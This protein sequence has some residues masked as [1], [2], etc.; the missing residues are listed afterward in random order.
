MAVTVDTPEMYAAMTDLVRLMR[1]YG[2]P[3]QATIGWKM[4]SELYRAG[5]VVMTFD[6]AG[7]PSV[8]ADPGISEVAGKIGVALITGPEHYAQWLY[9][10]GLGINRFSGNKGAARL[11]IQWR[12]S[13]DTF[14]REVDAGIRID[15]PNLAIYQLDAWWEAVV[16][17]ELEFWGKL[18][19]R[20][21]E[22]TD[23]RYW[24]FV[25]E[26]APISEAFQE[27]ISLAIAGGQ[28]VAEALRNAQRRIEDILE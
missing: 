14:L 16:Y 17:H 4:L 25:P 19:P 28:T 23:G 13:L 2:P 11:F 22:L 24:P 18:L 27:E 5:E 26:F 9:S 7:F 15:F 10:E 12:T 6:M 21:L 1:Y 8:F 20:S 3:G